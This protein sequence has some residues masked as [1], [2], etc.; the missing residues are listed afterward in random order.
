[1]PNIDCGGVAAQ[2][3]QL[4]VGVWAPTYCPERPP[5][6]QSVQA[7]YSSSSPWSNNLGVLCSAG[8][9]KPQT[10]F[11]EV[12]GWYAA[13][14]SWGS[15]T[16]LF[17]AR[18]GSTTRILVILLMTGNLFDRISDKSCASDPT[19]RDSVSFDVEPTPH[20]IAS[21]WRKAIAD[22]TV[23]TTV[24]TTVAVRLLGVRGMWGDS[25]ATAQ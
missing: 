19:E 15:S 6:P 25:G 9:D 1:M 16:V 2:R 10:P 24:A 17:K 7:L 22:A 13:A 4:L 23:A 3:L 8:C 21:Q 18:I 12:H 5:S 11:P 14:G 20:H